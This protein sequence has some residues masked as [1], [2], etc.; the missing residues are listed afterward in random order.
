MGQQ[1]KA[2]VIGGG[3]IGVTSAFALAQKGWQV[4]LIDSRNGVAQGASWGNGRQLS[5]SHTNALANPGILGQ[6]PRLLA[7]CDQAFRLGLRPDIGFASWIG[8]FLSNCTPAAYRRNTLDTLALA[9]QSRVAMDRLLSAFPVEFD[10]RR[11]GKIVLLNSEG[12]IAK[13]EAS[14]ALKQSTGLK[15]SILRYDELVELEPALKQAGEPILGALYSPGDE[16]GDCNMFSRNLLN[17]A[18]SEFGVKFLGGRAVTRISRGKNGPLAKLEDGDEIEAKLIVLANGSSINRLLRSLG[19][20]LPI[21]PMKGYSFTAPLG[22]AAPTASIT[23]SKRRIV[24]TNLGER[25]L[26]AGIAEMG[27]VDAQVDPARL[28]SMVDAAREALPQAAVYSEADAGWA[29]LRPLTPNS[30]PITRIMEPGI[31][32]NGGH[33]MLGW[34]LAMGSAERLVEIVDA[35]N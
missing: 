6:V 18:R 8:Q 15:Q 12:D 4:E 17:I 34:T 32:V 23:D 35:A 19:H 3:I 16:T 22:N 28:A 11:V 33:G 21:E 20:R 5:Y 2:L 13:A 24:F 10:R 25:M 30:Q 29:G 9:Q 1:N 26:V 31:A 14:I 7:G 27:R